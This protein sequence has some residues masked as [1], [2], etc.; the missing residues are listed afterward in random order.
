MQISIPNPVIPHLK[1]AA[2]KPLIPNC[3]S[4]TPNCKSQF[5]LVLNTDLPSFQPSSLE[6]Q[7][8]LHPSLTAAPLS[9]T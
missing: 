6:Y 1:I 5:F 3:K 7:Y 9:V 4:Q 2:L 8:S